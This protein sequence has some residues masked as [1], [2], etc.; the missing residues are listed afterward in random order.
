MVRVDAI[1][2]SVVAHPQDRSLVANMLAGAQNLLSHPSGRGAQD[3]TKSVLVGSQFSNNVLVAPL[4]Y[5]TERS[6][7]LPDRFRRIAVW[8][9]TPETLANSR[10]CASRRL[11]SLASPDCPYLPAD[12]A[13]R[14]CRGVQLRF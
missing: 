5:A 7:R 14:A 9:S 6:T 11:V 13:L 12:F 3:H 8:R 1:P 10:S 2:C 4:D